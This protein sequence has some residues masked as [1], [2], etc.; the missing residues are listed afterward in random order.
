MSPRC[1]CGANV[2]PFRLELSCW[3]FRSVPCIIN[4]LRTLLEHRLPF[5]RLRSGLGVE[6][7][8]FLLSFFVVHFPDITFS[9]FDP[10][11]HGR[12]LLIFLFCTCRFHIPVPMFWIKLNQGSWRIWRPWTASGRPFHS[13]FAQPRPGF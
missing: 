13:V 11:V 8:I 2:L 1:L 9:L 5:F 10:P 3:L 4:A 12:P 6:C 7:I